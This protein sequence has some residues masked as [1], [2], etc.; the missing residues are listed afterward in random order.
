MTCSSRR[1]DRMLLVAAAAGLLAWHPGVA[2]S[3]TTTHADAQVRAVQVPAWVIRGGSRRALEPGERLQDGDEIDTGTGARALLALA[4]GSTIKLGENARFALHGMRQPGRPG[5]LFRAALEV[6]AGA[7]RFTTSAVYKVA[8]RRD[9]QISLP[10]ATI[11]IRGTDVWGKS[12]ADRDLVVLIEG[13]VSLTRRDGKRLDLDRPKS[14]YQALRN[15]GVLPI[16]TISDDALAQAARETE[17]EPG[18]GAIGKDG[19]WLLEADPGLPEPDAQ[20][21]YRRLRDAGYPVQVHRVRRSGATVYAV[22]LPGLL[23]EADG[24][25]IAV[26]LKV[27]F[28]LQRVTV[29]LP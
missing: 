23:S 2:V 8:A 9:V 28:G 3:A 25:A 17:I 26:R 13:Q 12:T 6:V 14:L 19:K 27:E 18:Q 4:D 21:L 10:T 20:A 16:E 5:G 1:A 29:V 15:A 22:R 7:F 11:G 24:A